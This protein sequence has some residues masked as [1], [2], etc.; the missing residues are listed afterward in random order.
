MN[1]KYK[2]STGFNMTKLIKMIQLYD[3]RINKISP[4]AVLSNKRMKPIL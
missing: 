2:S 3:T 1:E 4:I